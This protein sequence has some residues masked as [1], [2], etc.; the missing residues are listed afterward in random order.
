MTWIV[1]RGIEVGQIVGLSVNRCAEL[2]TQAELGAEASV[3]APIVSDKGF[4]LGKTEETDRV[5][6]RF[7]IRAES[8][9]QRIGKRIIVAGSSNAGKSTLA[10]SLL[11]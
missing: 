10:G 8:P 11:H 2:I 6:A 7:A 4:D 9:Q 1:A 5:G 3:D